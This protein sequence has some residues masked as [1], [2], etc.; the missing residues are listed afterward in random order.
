MDGRYTILKGLLFGELVSLVS[1][2]APNKPPTRRAFFTDLVGVGLR[3]MLYIMGDFNSV[4]DPKKDRFESKAGKM[5]SWLIS[6]G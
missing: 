3:G 2:Y 4:V 1:L 6:W 5:G